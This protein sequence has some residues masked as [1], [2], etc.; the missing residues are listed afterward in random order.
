[1]IH[2]RDFARLVAEDVKNKV[3][4][5]QRAYLRLPEQRDRWSQALDDLRG[6]LGRQLETLDDRE[7]AAHVRFGS[8][9][10][11]GVSALAEELTA[12]ES[13]RNKIG[14]FMFYVGDRIDEAARL[15]DGRNDA[16]QD[17]ADRLA[18]LERAITTHRSLLSAAGIEP[19]IVD[20]ALWDALDGEWRFD[21]I[22]PSM[23][24]ASDDEQR[25]S[26]TG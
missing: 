19:T 8:L 15:A 14:R 12:L 5:A 24:D 7:R 2:D 11:Q 6:N 4:E 13:H 3:S 18:L 21:G 23:I 17:R 16:G 26:A 1:M 25:T 20:Q 22:T 10:K 9:G